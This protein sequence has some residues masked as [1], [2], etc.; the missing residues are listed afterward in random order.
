ML[1]A[2]GF[3]VTAFGA[4]EVRGRLTSDGVTGRPAIIGHGWGEERIYVGALNV[5]FGSGCITLVNPAG[6]YSCSGMMAPPGFPGGT[7]AMFTLCFDRGIAFSY[8]TVELTGAPVVVDPVE[9]R[10]PAH[11]SVA[12]NQHWTE[13][14]QEP[15]I[16]GTDFYQTFVA[17]TPYITR[18]GTRLAG[19]GGDHQA[20]KLNYAIYETN[21]NPPSA[22]R[23]ISPIRSVFMPGTMDPIIHFAY[24]PYRSNEMTLVPGRSYAA[25]FWRDSSSTSPDFAICARTDRGSGYVNGYLYSGNTAIPTLDAYAYISGGSP[26]TIVNHAPIEDTATQELVGMGTR[27]GQLFRAS[28]GGLAAVDMVYTTGDP[29]PPILPVTFQVYD[30]VGGFPVGRAKVCYGM[31]G[32]YQGRAAAIWERGDVPLVQGR[33]YYLE[34]STPT[35][36]NTWKMT[37]NLPGQGYVNRVSLGAADLLMSIAEYTVGG[38]LLG[39]NVSTLN[40]TVA[41]GQNLRPDTIG[42]TNT[43]IGTMN[44]AVSVN[45]PWMSADP[46]YGSSTGETD[47]ITISYATASLA[48]GAYTGYITVTANATNSPQT[49]AVTL[50]VTS[51][52]G[53]FN[54]DE[55]VDLDDFAVFQLCFNG[56]N[57]PVG[58][59]CSVNA[60][61]D[62]DEDVDLDDFLLFARCFNGSGRSPACQ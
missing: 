34:W 59:N 60:D 61:L 46:T 47:L 55:D 21:A 17:V 52:A 24:V 56:P 33:Y 10:T 5:G 57:A 54:G 18:V 16:W 6:W 26:D 36:V 44:Y 31:S 50:T 39:V 29:A 35:P 7:Y 27:F 11:Y 51:G 12:Y 48:P 62:N 28:G 30:S 13:W 38:P 15:W 53:D 32:Y 42:I 2:G 40:R 45:A 3:A 8:S 43:G 25:R 4:T 9:L 41:R 22:W 49:V 37:E 14:G 1:A 58:P 20:L 23:R 19:K